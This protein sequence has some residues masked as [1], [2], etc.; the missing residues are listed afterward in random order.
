VRHRTGWQYAAAGLFIAAI[1]A[2]ISYNDGLFVARLAGNHDRQ[3]YLY[4]LLADGLI[5]VCLLALYEASRGGAPRSRWAMGGL[6][7]GVGMTLSMNAGAGVAHSVLDAVIDGL[8]PVVFFIAVE[9]V[10]WHV[11]R[12]G[13]VAGEDV[14]QGVSPHSPATR[15]RMVPSDKLAA[16]KACHAAT[17]AAGNPLSQNQLTARFGITRA[18]AQVIAQKSPAGPAPAP[19]APPVPAGASG[20][21]TLPP[22]ARAALN[23]DARG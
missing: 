16:A 3:A 12:G 22:A 9:V 13:N 2:V 11:R 7:L 17:V 23:G 19:G 15:P 4:P 8:V 21:G 6:I 18:E 5:V 14:Q 1:A 10:L 20:P